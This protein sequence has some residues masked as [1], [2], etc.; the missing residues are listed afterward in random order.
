MGRL[1]KAADM[2]YLVI[3]AKHP[4][5]FAMF[6]SA[7]SPFSIVDATPCKRDPQAKLPVACRKLSLQLGFY[8]SHAQDWNAPVGG[9]K[10]DTETPEQNISA[11]G[12]PDCDRETCMTMD[13]IWDYKKN[14]VN[15]K[16]TENLIC[17][18]VEVASNG[19]NDLL[20]VDQTSEGWMPQPS[21]K[22]LQA[23]GAWKKETSKALYGTMASPFSQLAWGRCT[24]TISGDG[25]ILHRHVFNWPT[26][27]TLLLPGLENHIERA[28]E[29]NK[30]WLGN[31][32]QVITAS[33]ADGVIMTFSAV[34]QTKYFP[35]L[36]SKSKARQPS[37]PCR[38]SK[39]R[40]LGALQGA[41]PWR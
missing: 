18:L 12:F 36:L 41:V 16:S 34:S 40:H 20:A 1:A 39:V 17:N 35:Q 15:W 10:G 8:Y 24:K 7:A 23:V 6:K 14:D 38:R 27:D 19:G 21:P 28:Y 29:L 25:T 30:N 22:R 3:T 31:Q 5:N 33:I 11:I 26:N 2:K 13:G 37:R 4:A 9:Y 32:R